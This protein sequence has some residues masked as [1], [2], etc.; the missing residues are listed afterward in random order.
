MSGHELTRMVKTWPDALTLAEVMS[1]PFLC[2]GEQWD[3]R[4]WKAV[5]MPRGL[6][7][8]H[9]NDAGCVTE[10]VLLFEPE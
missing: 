6:K 9:V 5:E 7:F 3:L 2:V 1:N 8:E 10:A 4:D